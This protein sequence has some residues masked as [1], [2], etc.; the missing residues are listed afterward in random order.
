MAFLL[1]DLG[2]SGL[3]DVDMDVRP[4]GMAERSAL[5]LHQ[6]IQGFV[7]PYFDINGNPTPHYRARLQDTTARYKQPRN[8]NNAVY[9][10]KGFSKSLNGHKFV[11]ITE[12]EKKAARAVK[13]GFPCVGLGG[14]YNW[15]NSA[16]TLPASAIQAKQHKGGAI[17]IGVGASTSLKLRLDE[18]DVDSMFTEYAA[19]FEDLVHLVRAE[20]LNVIIVFDSDHRGVINRCI[21]FNVQRAAARL[22]LELR[23]L[24]IPLNRVKQLMLPLGNHP[25]MGLDDYLVEYGEEALEKLIQDLIDNPRAFPSHPD[26]YAHVHRKLQFG[27]TTRKAIS[28]LGVTIVSDLDAKGRRLRARPND[29]MFYFDTATR[30][31]IGVTTSALRAS[32]SQGSPLFDEFKSLLYDRYGLMATD[33]RVMTALST[34]IAAEAPIDDVTTRKG[35]FTIGDTM[36]HQINS[37]QYVTCSAESPLQICL[38]GDKGVM[39]ESS[40]VEDTIDEKQLQL[41]VNRQMSQPLKPWWFETLASTR[42]KDSIDNRAK[43]AT[44]LLYYM[45]PWLFRWK[46]TQLPVELVTGESG[47]GKSTLYALRLHI[48][49]GRENLRNR[50]QSLKDW[51][52]SVLDTGGLHVTDN[53]NLDSEPQLG[54]AI[55]DE[56]CR[57]VTEPNPAVE[58]RRYFTERGLIRVPAHVVFALTAIKLPFRQVDLMQRSMHI[59]LER[60]INLKDDDV[61]FESDW[62]NQQLLQRGG[63]VSWLA[64]HLVVL[65]KF[66]QLA[67]TDWNSHY[68]AKYRLINFEQAMRIMCRLFGWDDEWIPHYLSSATEKATEAVDWLMQGVK[69]YA[70]DKR[71]QLGD[72]LSTFTFSLQAICDWAY[73]QD[74]FRDCASLQK[75]SVISRWIVA[76][77]SMVAKICGVV[78]AG[79]KGQRHLYR[80]VTNDEG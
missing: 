7:I 35:T 32:G 42:I 2:R 23:H 63:R 6:N 29:D 15:R 46:G 52:A 71:R 80:I 39:F 38:N 78:P 49:T 11:F 10:P 34:Q 70:E 19:G 73:E 45:S 41:E 47:S 37:Q 51:H 64:H 26:I 69:A 59:Q 17:D 66:F 76:H 3:E 77:R 44:A 25:K 74:E 21:T 20:K 68:R 61:I 75:A 40:A 33:S 79:D 27:K 58:M 9:F 53:A 31:L 30:Q 5:D 50:P 8:S 56:M 72:K 4:L 13:S 67:N 43:K 1:E 28:Q 14:V 60:S 24:Q 16:V 62:L 18:I 55:S 54:Q 48:L 22:G 12:G 57:M 36:Y 65:H